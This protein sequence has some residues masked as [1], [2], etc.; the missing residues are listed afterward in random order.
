MTLFAGLD[1][2]GVPPGSYMARVTAG[3]ESREASFTLEMD[4]RVSSTPDEIRAWT[5]RLDETSTLLEATL[6]SLAGLRKARAQIDALM[7]QYPGDTALGQA[8]RSALDAIDAWDHEIIQ[9]LHE[10]YEDEDAWETRLAGQ[11]RYLLDVIDY[12]GA[13][14]TEGALLRLADLKSQWATLETQL[15]GIRSNHIEPINEWARQTDVP[16]VSSE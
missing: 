9:P 2:P 1:G 13:P 16:H 5:S 10:T 15:D 3:G 4:P 7:D 14:V 6:D 11:I 8:G 12:T